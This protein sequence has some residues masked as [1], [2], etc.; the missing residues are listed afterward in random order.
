MYAQIYHQGLRNIFTISKECWKP[1]NAVEY[2]KH[3]A[4]A[5]R[6]F[7]YTSPIVHSSAHALTTGSNSSAPFSDS[8]LVPLKTLVD[9]YWF[10]GSYEFCF[11]VRIH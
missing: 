1:K 4:C 7:K 9:P 10:D 2:G 3:Q 5:A 11:G 8:S 6:H